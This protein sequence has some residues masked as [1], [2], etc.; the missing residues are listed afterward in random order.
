VTIRTTE[1]A[2]IRQ[3][4]GLTLICCQTPTQLLSLPLLNSTGD[5]NK[6]KQPMDSDKYRDIIHQLP[7][8][9]KLTPL[10]GINLIYYQF[11]IKKRIARNKNKTKTTFPHLLLLPRL[12]FI[13][14]FL[15]PL[16]FHT[17][18]HHKQCRGWGIDIVVCS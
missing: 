6:M 7:S 10:G 16:L 18:A 12:I 9:A 11:R 3:C 13:P 5:E 17:H 8:Q 15:T 2:Y 4:G 14:S 1:Q